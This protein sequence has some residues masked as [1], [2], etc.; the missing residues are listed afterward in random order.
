MD[1]IK[2]SIGQTVYMILKPEQPGMVTGI[3]FRHGGFYYLV[4]WGN[5][6]VERTHYEIEL[7]SEKSFAPENA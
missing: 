2:Y 3:T 6:L 7:T 5:D 4:T 1:A